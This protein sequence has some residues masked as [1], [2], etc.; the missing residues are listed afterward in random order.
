M[1]MANRYWVGGTG[2]WDTT[3][4]TNWSATSG[5]AG[6][7]SAAEATANAVAPV[8]GNPSPAIVLLAGAVEVLRFNKDTYFSGLAAAANTVY[9]TPGQGI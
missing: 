5:G 7:T 6:G 2:T 1:I 4:T 8:G 3:D 9:V